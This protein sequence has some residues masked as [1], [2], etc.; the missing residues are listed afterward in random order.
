[1]TTLTR[2]LAK[3]ML[4]SLAAYET[5]YS[6]VT[7]SVDPERQ[8]SVKTLRKWRDALDVRF[9]ELSCDW[10]AYKD[11]TDLDNNEFNRVT[12]EGPI[13]K[14]NDA[15]FQKVEAEYIDLCEKADDILE[16]DNPKSSDKSVLESKDVDLKLKDKKLCDILLAQIEAETKCI[17]QGTFKLAEEVTNISS[18]L[19]PQKAESLLLRCRNLADRLNNGLQSLVLQCLPLMDDSDVQEK[20]EKHNSF[21]SNQRGILSN[22]SCKIVERTAPKS[23]VTNSGTPLIHK[24]QTHLKKIDPPKF[25]GDI[26]G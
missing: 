20:S 10:R 18:V 25:D 24:E 4:K 15:W 6:L 11:D 2:A 16:E 9:I 13:I 21:V 23:D 8:R 3:A 19:D 12:D 1:M 17:E 5:I 22:I 26:I 14:H 7:K